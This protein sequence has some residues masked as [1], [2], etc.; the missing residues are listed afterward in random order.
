MK[1][2]C[3]LLIM[4]IA[5]LP[6]FVHADEG[7]WIVSELNKQTLLRMK[8]LGFMLSSEQVYDENNPCLAQAVAIFGRGCSSIA[9]SDQGLLF[10]NHHCGFGAIQQLSSVEHDYL[11]NGFVSQKFE[12]ELPVPGLTV[13]FLK[14]FVNITDSIAPKLEG[15]T[16]EY[17]RITTAQKLA[18]EITS[19]INTSEFETADVY[20]FFQNNQYFLVEYEIFRDVRLVF[21]APAS[22]GK[23]GG[24]TDNWMWPRHTADFSIFRVYADKNNKP[25]KYSVDNKPYKPR[26]V[27]E[28]SL[29]G[30]KEGDYAMSIGFPGSTSRYLSSWGINQR[31]KNVNEP[32]IVVRGIKQAIWKD[33]MN[34]SDEIRIKYASKYQ[35]SSNYWKN[36]IGMNRGLKKLD[37][38]GRRQQE[39]AAFN[40]WVNKSEKTKAEYGDALNL[41]EKGYT[42]SDQDKGNITFLGEAFFSG[43]EI[44]RI[45]NT[46]AH[47]P[48]DAEGEELKSFIEDRIEPLYKDYDWQTDR[49]VLAAMLKVVKENVSAEAL[50]EIYQEID[51]VY[52]GNY[53]HY[54]Y[55]LFEK[56][57]LKDKERLLANL[58]SREAF[59]A[60]SEQDPAFK[61]SS[62]VLM[63]YMEIAQNLSKYTY[64]IKK[65]ERLYMK[66]LMEMYPKKAF[67]PDA[68]FTMRLSYGS[69]KGYEPF[70]GAWYNYYTTDKGV[71]QKY[72]PEDPEFDLNKDVLATIKSK[73]FGQYGNKDGSLN[74]CFLSNNDITG[75]NSGSPVFDKNGRVIGLAFDGNWEAMSGDIAF[76][77]DLQ[78]MI[79]VDIRYVLFL[80]EKWGKCDRLIK[81]LKLVK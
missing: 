32:R 78:R 80:V 43:A 47:L 53:E 29:Q 48:K 24:D 69:I 41:L 77:T 10:T 14:R 66:G 74:T 44:V 67:S 52:N 61:L 11:K 37:I 55:D 3:T 73:D 42:N 75:G 4:M 56:T 62:S 39:E 71:V 19:R 25:A 9:V 28:V 12:E 65:G 17:E 72:N 57:V 22:I 81:E 79:T 18:K 23:Y 33:A 27:A 59:Q 45:A 50:P 1:R 21:T 46:I 31:I 15:I 70:D 76:E 38:I 36:S 40:N 2:I 8:E 54:A 60:M 13:R 34:S 51:S 30:Y 5:L 16:D 63:K 35:S 7:M 68:N 64:D 26:Y 49:Q 6:S 58:S 20:P